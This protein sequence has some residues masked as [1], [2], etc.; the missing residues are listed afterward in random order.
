MKKCVGACVRV[1]VTCVLLVVALSEC[2]GECVYVVWHRYSVE[3]IGI[4][5]LCLIPHLSFLSLLSYASWRHL[6]VT[7]C[8]TTTFNWFVFIWFVV[9]IVFS[10][11]V[12]C[13]HNQYCC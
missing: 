12:L 11:D 8:Q 1:G 6:A 13:I 9:V 3:D 2:V 7:A 10:L 5:V 4:Q